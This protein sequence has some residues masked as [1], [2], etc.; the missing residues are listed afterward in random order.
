MASKCLAS[1]R[2]RKAIFPDSDSLSRS[3]FTAEGNIF[4]SRAS[5]YDLIT[6]AL[7][8]LGPYRLVTSAFGVKADKCG[9]DLEPSSNEE[10]LGF[11]AFFMNAT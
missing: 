11:F 1:V 3:S 7:T 2:L 5:V 10:F 8:G 9:L 6:F 4:L